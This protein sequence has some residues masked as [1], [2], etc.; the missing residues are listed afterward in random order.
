MGDFNGDHKLDVVA[1]DSPAQFLGA[2]GNGDGT[3]QAATSYP[4]GTAPALATSFLVTD[5]NA[6]G[7]SIWR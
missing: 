3:F 6:M 5:L 4:L 1:L 7:S 2:A